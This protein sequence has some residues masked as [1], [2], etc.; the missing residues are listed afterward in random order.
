MEAF[1]TG[2]GEFVSM[3]WLQVSQSISADGAVTGELLACEVD[4]LVI[5]EVGEFSFH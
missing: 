1:R 2:F 4:R 5:T 3:S